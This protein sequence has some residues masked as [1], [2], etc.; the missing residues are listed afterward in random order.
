MNTRAFALILLLSSACAAPPVPASAGSRPN[1]VVVLADDMG[2][3]DLG[4]YGSEI[5]TP[6]IDRLARQGLRFTQFYNAARCCPSRASLLTGLYPHEAG[7][8]HM[9]ADRK[10]PSYQGYLNDRCVT[11]AEALRPQGYQTLMAGKWHVG[12]ERPHWPVDRGFDNSVALIGSGRHYFMVPPGR[13]LA[14]DDRPFTPPAND[15]YLTDFL[16]TSALELLDQAGRGQKPFLLY[17]AYTA[18]HWPLHAKPEDVEHYR[19]TYKEGWDVLRERR[20]R[21]MIQEGIVD[22]NWP[23][24]PRDPRVPAWQDCADKDWEAQR[25]AV[26]AAQVECLDRGVGRIVAKLRDLGKLENTLILVLS[27]NGGCS[28]DITGQDRWQEDDIPKKTA[29]GRPIRIGNIPSI[30]PGPPDTFASYGIE[31]ANV[32]NTPFRLFKS[33]IHEGGISTPLIAHWPAVIKRPGLVHAPGHLIDLMPTCLELAGAEQ[34]GSL[35]LEG[36]SLVPLLRG[37]KAPKDREF[38]WEHEGNRAI[39]NGRWKLVAVNKEAW[40]LYDLEAD[41]TELRN[42]A[43]DEPQRVRDMIV[44]YDA[45]AQRCGVLPW[46]DGHIT[47]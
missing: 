22:A 1:I 6:N 25:M 14:R 23:L 34:R 24:A 18:P 40:E 3:S 5:S 32:S 15:F 35:P 19:D 8:G 33:W 41:R 43:K 12:N 39:R 44:R 30:V 27:D 9:V 38:F 7:V 29:D 10:T 2:F 31:W 16:T 20:H 36:R 42:R 47:K 4:C 26:Y 11:L 17:M 28:E 37:D 46:N 13:I 45:W 21:R